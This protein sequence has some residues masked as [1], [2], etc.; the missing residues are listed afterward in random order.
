MPPE[1]RRRRRPRNSGPPPEILAQW[2]PAERAA[3]ER[4]Q[5]LDTPTAEMGLSVRCVNTLEDLGVILCRD[6]VTKSTEELMEIPNFGETTLKEVIKAVKA[7]GLKPP[8][9][10]KRRAPAKKGAARRKKR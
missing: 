2:T 9:K 7:L 1:N 10:L 3:R 8:W 4:E 5:R 6:L